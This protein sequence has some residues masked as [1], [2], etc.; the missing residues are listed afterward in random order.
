[1]SPMFVPGP[2][3]VAPEVLAAQA[4]PMLPQTA[5][6]YPIPGFPGKRLRVGLPGSRYPQLCAGIRVMLRQ[7]L[8][9]RSLAQG[10]AQ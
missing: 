1:M 5:F 10:G 4:R 8:I 9:C 2:V 3:D 6:L 7:W